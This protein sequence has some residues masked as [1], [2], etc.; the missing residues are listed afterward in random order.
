MCFSATAS[1]GAGTVLLA[2]G[3]LALKQARKPSQVPFAAVPL[4]FSAQQFVEGVVW[5]SLTHKKYAGWEA[6]S[7]TTFLVF[8]LVVWTFWV[9]FS[10]TLLEKEVRRKKVLWVLTGLGTLLGGYLAYCLVAYSI[11]AEIVSYHILYT[12][13]FP[14]SLA[15]TTTVFYFVPT[16]FPPFISSNRQITLFGIALVAAYVTAKILYPAYIISVWCFFA[17]ILSVVVLYIVTKLN[18]QAAAAKDYALPH[19][20]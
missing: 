18:T 7:T 14:A 8:A 16:V 11:K 4:L 17:A 3:A 9:P 12:W 10:I 6:W 15:W 1:F 2:I 19:A 20:L 13:N 5:L